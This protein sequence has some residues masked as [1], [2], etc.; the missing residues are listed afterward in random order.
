MN[1]VRV[2][3]D[4]NLWLLKNELLEYDCGIE[5]PLQEMCETCDNKDCDYHKWMSCQKKLSDKYSH[6]R[7]VK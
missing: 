4:I 2:L 7:E 6:D 5:L 3:T 1:I